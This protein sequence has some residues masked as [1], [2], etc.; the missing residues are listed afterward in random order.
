MAD[1]KISELTALA[2][3]DVVD[4][5]LVPIVDTSGT[6]TKSFTWANLKAAL[7]T[8]LDTLYVRF[9]GTPSNNQL[10]VWTSADTLEGDAGLTWTGSILELSHTNPVIKL[11]ET[12]ATTDNK[13]WSMKAEG[14]EFIFQAIA[15]AG[16]GGGS[17]WA[18]GRTG[19]EITDMTGRRGGTDR[20]KLDNWNNHIAMSNAA[21]KIRTTSAH[22]LTLGA[23]STDILTLN[24][25]G[26]ADFSGNV[27]LGDSD[28]IYLGA[29]N[30]LQIYHSGAHSLIQHSGTGSLYVDSANNALL[31]VNTNEN[32]ILAA[33]NGAVTLYHNAVAKLATTSTGINV[34]GYVI[35]N[36]LLQVDGNSPAVK[37]QEADTTTA[38]RIVVSSG[39]MYLQAGA[40]GSGTTPSTGVIKLTGYSNHETLLTATGHGS[41]DLYYDNSLKLST[42]ANGVAV[43]GNLTADQF[44][45]GDHQ[46]LYSGASNDL[47][48]GF[49]GTNSIIRSTSGNMYLD[50]V[51]P[52][53]LR[54]QG[55]W[56]KLATFVPGGAVNLYYNNSLKLATT[57]TGVTV[58]GTL[59]TDGISVG[60]NE[61]AYFGTGN[62]L[63]IV[64]DG[65]N[66]YVRG[67]NGTG[68][69]YVD[70][71]GNTTLRVNNTENAVRCVANGAVTLYYDNV[72]KL[73]TRNDGIKVTGGLT[74]TV[75]S[76]T[77]TVIDPGNGSIQYKT[78]AANT[79]FTENIDNGQ[80]VLLMIDDGTAYTITWPTT[81][82]LTDSG[83]AP[84]L[85][86]TGYT[87]ISLW[88]MNGTLYGAKVNS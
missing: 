69:M 75:Y 4:T 23:N 82:W 46:F 33:A 49:D 86:T 19:T 6:E 50:A 26:S 13:I 32:A 85:E 22:T 15:D 38:A 35:A 14:E 59:T 61:Y 34:T 11:N 47:R 79:T 24:T 17:L 42:D 18:V 52:I 71:I 56:G 81:T 37:L 65:V 48:F 80:S 31:R 67:L 12:D 54:E 20:I 16:G 58:T 55:T 39:D 68:V 1:K 60:D 27:S 66:S 83:S 9:T 57:N 3:G 63:Q 25:D 10:G 41:V 40:S 8:Y 21:A 88:Q 45:L 2:S 51:G 84:T 30:D 36:D 78:L 64:H 74:E 7:K 76:L 44:T 62:D 72:V 70:S 5:D 53:M 43:T 77:G 87:A 28:S 29:G 73:A